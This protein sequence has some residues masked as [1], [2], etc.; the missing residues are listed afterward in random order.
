MKTKSDQHKGGSQSVRVI[1][2]QWRSRRIS[3]PDLPQLRPTPDRVRETL[4]NW[5]A[6]IIDGAQCLDLFA[7]SGALGIEALSRGA[8]EV[9]FLEQSR[10]AAVSLREQLGLLNAQHARVIESDALHYLQRTQ[11]HFDIVF[12][13]PPYDSDLLPQ[14]CELLEKRSLLRPHAR[15]YIEQRTDA[16]LSLPSQWELLR[17][18]RAGQVHYHLAGTLVK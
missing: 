3:F 6:P 2:G 4:F 14:I 13:D 10:E 11:D 16:T 7:G 17:S 12:L 8:A 9:V 1:G 18:K 15:I 5:L